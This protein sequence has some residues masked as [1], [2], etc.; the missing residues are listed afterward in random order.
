MLR[1]CV[2]L[3]TRG[4]RARVHDL[5]QSYKQSTKPGTASLVTGMVVDVTRRKRDLLAENAFL[6]QRMI[7]LKRQTPRP[8]L[9]TRDRGLLV[10]LASRV[11]G[12]TDALIV[13][14]PDMLKKW[15]REGFRIDWRR[16][17]KGT[18]RTPRISPEAIAL[19]GQMA[20]ENRTWGAKRIRDERRKLGH[21]INQRTVRNY[22]KQ[23]RRDWPP[24]QSGQT[25]ATFLR[26]HAVR[27]GSV[28]SCRPTICSSAGSSS[29]SSSNWARDG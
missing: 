8:S 28:I 17:S 21:R 9:R 15:H 16:K 23:A 3:L 2:E 6:R 10:A 19:I 20:L 22:M 24:R 29:S 12:W 27:Y 4:L 14:K 11:R 13:V 18:H 26:N 7:V 25:W 5:N 1:R